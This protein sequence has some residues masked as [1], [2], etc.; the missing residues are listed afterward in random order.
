MVD[1]NM[2]NL[3]M[4]KDILKDSYTV[5]PLLSANKLFEIL[6]NVNPDMILL[7]VEMP[8]MNGLETIRILKKNPRTEEIPVIFLTSR[9]DSESQ[10][11]GLKVICRLAESYDFEAA[12]EKI[13]ELAGLVS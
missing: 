4:G 9:T 5:F 6:E 12:L 2:S 13:G 10:L 11:E 1:D 7:D 8:E 3:T